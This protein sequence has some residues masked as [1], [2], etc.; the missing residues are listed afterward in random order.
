MGVRDEPESE[1]TGQFLLCVYPLELPTSTPARLLVNR[2]YLTMQ[3]SLD[4]E[5][6]QNVP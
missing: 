3:P 1:E 2:C 5:Q 4:Q 6:S